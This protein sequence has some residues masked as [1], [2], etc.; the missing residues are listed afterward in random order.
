MKRVLRHASEARAPMIKCIRLSHHYAL[1][2]RDEKMQKEGGH[3]RAQKEVDECM[4]QRACALVKCRDDQRAKPTAALVSDLVDTKEFRLVAFGHQVG[5][6][7]TA[8]ALEATEA[9]AEED[10]QNVH[11]PGLLKSQACASEG[12]QAPCWS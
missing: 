9:R 7:R 2:L 6:E 5:K 12:E 8:E 11:L 3:R 4:A 1:V 10:C